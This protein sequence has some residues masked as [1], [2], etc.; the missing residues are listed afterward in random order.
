M[1]SIKQHRWDCTECGTQQGKNDQWFEGDICGECHD[2]VLTSEEQSFIDNFCLEQSQKI[3]K[4]QGLD[5]ISG[6]FCNIVLYG[7]DANEII[8]TVKYGSTDEN[9]S[10]SNEDEII[11]DRQTKEII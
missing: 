11:L 2:Q 7:C 6:G 9:G 3:K 4:E 10:Y 5:K 1:S 8:L